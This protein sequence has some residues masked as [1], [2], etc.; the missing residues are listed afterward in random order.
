MKKFVMLLSSLLIG[1]T[2]MTGCG[3]QGDAQPS[4]VNVI[5]LR[6]LL[7]WGW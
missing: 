1:M 7:P 3:A 2:L 5:A 6:D 4:A